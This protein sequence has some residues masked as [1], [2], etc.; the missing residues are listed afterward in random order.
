MILFDSIIRAPG[1]M[2]VKSSM[3]L[4]MRAIINIYTE[5]VQKIP[6]T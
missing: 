1:L 3:I 2:K 5:L 4:Q 6:L